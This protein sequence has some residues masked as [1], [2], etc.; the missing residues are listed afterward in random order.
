MSRKVIAGLD[1]SPASLAAAEWAAREARL[2]RLPLKLLHAVEEWVPSYGYASRTG[3]TPSPQYWGERIPRETSRQLAERHPGLEITTEQ[4][5]GRPLT[6]LAAAAQEAEVLVL[7]SRGLGAVAGFLVGS[8]S[9]AVLAHAERPVVVVRSGTWMDTPYQEAPDGNGPQEGTYRPVVLGLDLSRPCD[10]LLDHAFDAAAAR[11]APLRVIHGW[12]M[13]PAF[14]FDP[15][16]LAPEVRDGMA[17]GTATALGDALRPWR[18]KYPQVRVEE[19]CS[20]GQAAGQL[21]EASADASLVVVGRRIRRSAIGTHLGPVAHAVLHHSTA[22][23][24][25]IPHP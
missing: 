12:S 25:V 23:V 22:P 6:V 9:Q 13:P 17:A 10:E 8:V 24:A 18:G 11:R 14:S 15:A 5:D 7:G 16:L 21:V 3:A 2:R 1:G 4:V 20:V 19:V